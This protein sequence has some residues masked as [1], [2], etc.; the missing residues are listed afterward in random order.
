[1]KIAVVGCGFVGL[2]NILALASKGHDV[3]GIEINPDRFKRLS[4]WRTPVHEPMFDQLLGLA[5]DGELEGSISFANSTEIFANQEFDMVF[6]AVNTLHHNNTLTDART[7]EVIEEVISYYGSRNRAPMVVLKGTNP[8][9]SIESI[10]KRN[11]L[12]QDFKLIVAP[13]FLREGHAFA[14][15]MTPSRHVIGTRD[16]LVDEKFKHIID[17]FP[18]QQFWM[19]HAQAEYVKVSCNSL[20]AAQIALTQEVIRGADKLNLGVD[21]IMD[22]IKADERLNGYGRNPTIGWGG[23]CLPPCSAETR[24][25]VPNDSLLYNVSSSLTSNINHWANKLGNMLPGEVSSIGV[26]G[27]SFKEG[28]TSTSNSPIMSFLNHLI[29]RHTV[30]DVKAY[31]PGYVGNVNSVKITHRINAQLVA[32]PTEAIRDV[33]LIILGCPDKEFR[34]YDPVM[35]KFVASNAFVFDGFNDLNQASWESAGF[36]YMGLGRGSNRT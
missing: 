2:A 9:G 12:S 21:S 28:S 5:R 11:N 34:E 25:H 26:W 17:D 8:I 4:M 31:V 32:D 22:A 35:A 10:I 3:V 18:A 36:I 14:D 7:Q 6:I 16:S 27:L 24:K 33:S 30:S 15:V 1:M 13:E 23:S 19:S 29:S 20:L